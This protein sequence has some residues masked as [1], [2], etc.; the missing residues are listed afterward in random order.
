[1]ARV[2][3]GAIHHSTFAE[4]VRMTHAALTFLIVIANTD[5]NALCFPSRYFPDL[6]RFRTGACR[7]GRRTAG[8]LNDPSPLPAF[9][10]RSSFNHG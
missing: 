3:A 6:A 9:D 1:M 2:E 10:G 8:R 5:L 7:I 4:G